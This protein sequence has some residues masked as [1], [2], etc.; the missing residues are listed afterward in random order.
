MGLAGPSLREKR[1]P[2]M[3]EIV[4][5]TVEDLRAGRTSWRVLLMLITPAFAA[6]VAAGLVRP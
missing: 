3:S 5:R 6:G 4:I 1:S 2:T